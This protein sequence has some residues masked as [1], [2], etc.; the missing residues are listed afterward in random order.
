MGRRRK[1]YSR[2][3]GILFLNG[4]L[5]VGEVVKKVN[6]CSSISVFFY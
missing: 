1:V 3:I 2:E 5:D 4:Y 6:I